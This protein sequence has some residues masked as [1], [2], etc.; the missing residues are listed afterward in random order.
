MLVVVGA[1]TFDPGVAG[2]P[3][4]ELDDPADPGGGA[5][6][7]DTD[8][9]GVPDHLDNCVAVQNAAQRDHDGDG[10][11][12]ACDVCPHLA[13]TGADGDGDG[14]GDAC[15]PNPDTPGDR[16]AFFEGFDEPISWHVVIGSDTWQLHGGMLHQPDLGAAHQLVRD[17]TPDLG[18]L[19]VDAK[20]RVNQVSTNVTSRRSTGLVLGYR[21]TEDY[22]FCG[23]AAQGQSTQINAGVVS[24]DFFG[25]PQFT[26]NPAAVGPQPA[27]YWVTLQARVRRT[28]VS[29]T[30]L[31]CLGERDVGGSGAA[32][33]ETTR[34]ASG[35]VGVRTNGADAS[36]DYVFVVATGG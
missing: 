18:E 36:F 19:F 21:G 26:Y 24:R 34:G 6:P 28:Q 1:C 17:D 11:G 8:G 15:D 14:V 2:G 16:I 13:D 25:N 32:A 23:I 31:D 22:L 5:G 27:G 35:D 29:T 10:I 7:I 33:Y 12:D 20:L 30:R 3:A 4:G 9:D